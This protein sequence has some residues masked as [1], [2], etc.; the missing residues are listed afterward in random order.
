[1]CGRLVRLETERDAVD[2]LL[3]HLVG[4]EV[5]GPW[6]GRD[7]GAHVAV[8]A[9]AGVSTA[10]SSS[11]TNTTAATT[12]TTINATPAITGQ[13]RRRIDFSR[14]LMLRR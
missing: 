9:A 2:P 4:H 1:M 14:D 12:A 3:L 13:L 8:A 10:T 7:L 6:V 11:I 5:A